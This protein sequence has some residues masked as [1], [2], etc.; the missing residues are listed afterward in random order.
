MKGAARLRKAPVSR[1]TGTAGDPRMGKPDAVLSRIIP[2]QIGKVSGG[3]ETSQYL[4]EK[5][6]KE[7]P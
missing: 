6:S 2:M 3:T 1:L 4:E 5:K 7:I